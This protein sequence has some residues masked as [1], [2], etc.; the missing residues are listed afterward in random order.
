MGLV[1]MSYFSRISGIPETNRLEPYICSVGALYRCCRDGNGSF[2]VMMPD[3]K[4]RSFFHFVRRSLKL[5]SG[6]PRKVIALN[7]RPTTLTD[8]FRT[9][10]LA[11]QAAPS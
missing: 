4:S 7:K 3:N 1:I 10:I 9:M 11:P 8:K 5:P 2:R 6:W